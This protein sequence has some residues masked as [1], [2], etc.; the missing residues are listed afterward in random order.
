MGV[1]IPEGEAKKK[2]GVKR[3]LG[4]EKVWTHL[5]DCMSCGLCT[6][7]GP[8]APLREGNNIPENTKLEADCPP[9]QYYHFV[10]HSP[11]GRSWLAAALWYKNIP[12]TED[13]VK[14]FYTCTTC[15]LCDEVCYLKK[16]PI[17]RAMREEFVLRGA[18]LPEPIQKKDDTIVRTN[19]YFGG[20]NEVR[21]KW[22]KDLNLP[23][24]GELLYFAGCFSSYRYPEAARATV[25]ILRAAGQ[26][27]AYLAEKETC[28][29]NHLLISGKTEQAI[30]RIMPL[31]EAIRES[32]AKKV[33]FSCA[34]GY[35]AFDEY[36]ELLDG[37][38]F[39]IVHVS[40]YINQL[41][42]Q[43]K[44]KFRQNGSQKVTYHDPCAL[45]RFMN[46]YKAPRSVIQSVPGVELKEMLS[47]GRWSRC[48][49]S[50]FTLSAEAYPEYARTVAGWRLAEAKDAADIL[51]TSCPQ[52]VDNFTAAIKS[53]KM[54]MKVYDLPV[55]VAEAMGIKI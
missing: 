12:I 48:C 29:G 4:L 14:V 21:A 17:I 46:V 45:G 41:I 23:N 6:A 16:I 30:S 20:K 22:A 31:M 8:L 49:G 32:G 19:N 28:C 36:Q 54:N 53:D 55:F 24:K 44:L 37:L 10:S 25:G 51:V 1:G 33:L 43:K 5:K 40:E 13:V 9:Y 18:A 3:E 7:D 38:P 47:F 42:S 52:C 11:K 27:V 26:E 15:A 34:E 35:R 50:G 39:E 2:K